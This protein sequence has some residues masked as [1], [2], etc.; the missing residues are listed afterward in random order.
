MRAAFH[1]VTAF[2]THALRQHPNVAHEKNPD[3][4]DRLDLRNV[5]D[6]ALE[7]YGLRSRFH[8]QARCLNRLL[9]GVVAV[10]RHVRNNQ[11]AGRDRK[12][13]RLNSSHSQISYAV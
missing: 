6:T 5:T 8:E 3:R 2:L 4:H 12:S 1:L 13:T 10:N 7:L 11:S 9:G